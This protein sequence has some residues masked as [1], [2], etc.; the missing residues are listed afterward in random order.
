[1]EAAARNA[2]SAT[3]AALSVADQAIFMRLLRGIVEAN[4]DRI[5]TPTPLG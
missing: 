5:A 1:M 4:S 3:I 2:H